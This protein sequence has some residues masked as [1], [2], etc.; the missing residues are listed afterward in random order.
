M[1]GCPPLVPLRAAIKRVNETI[2]KVT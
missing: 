2:Q 1:C